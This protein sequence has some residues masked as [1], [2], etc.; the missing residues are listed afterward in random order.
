MT[1]HVPT[2]PTGSELL[3]RFLLDIRTLAVT[4]EA[5]AGL[6]ERQEYS[7]PDT[8]LMHL[9]QSVAAEAE[10]VDLITGPRGQVCLR[11]L[12]Q[13]LRSGVAA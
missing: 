5:E 11:A 1:A 3:R 6:A 13:V 2:C 7:D 9:Q 8:A 12:D 4:A 10:L